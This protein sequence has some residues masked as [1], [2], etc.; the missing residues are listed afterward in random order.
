MAKYAYHVGGSQKRFKEWQLYK[1]DAE[2]E[3]AFDIGDRFCLEGKDTCA[4]L[5]RVGEWILVDLP[6]EMM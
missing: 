6:E 3:G 5:N 4:H 2:Y 1:V